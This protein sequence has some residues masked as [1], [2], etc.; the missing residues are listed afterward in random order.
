MLRFVA[1]RIALFI[2]VVL[3]V[4]FIIFT[5][6]YFTPSDPV[7]STLGMNITEEE[8]QQKS[9]ELG[10]DKPFTV[11]F[12]RYLGNIVH[13][14]LGVSY[15]N[16]RSVADQ[17]WE[18]AGKTLLLGGIGMLITVA[19]GIPSGIISATRQYSVLDYSVTGISLFFASMPNFWL[20]LMLIILF[21]LK[22][23]WLP[24]T[25]ISS[26]KGWVLPCLTLG[27]GPLAN[28]TRIT[29]S[30]MLD[31]I[32]QD[33][34]RTAKAKGLSKRATIIKHAL[35]NALIPVITVIGFMLSMI[36]G[37]SAVIEGVF[38][39]PGIGAMLVTAISTADYPLIM[40]SVLFISLF[41]CIV[42]LIVDILYGFIDPRIKAQYMDHRSHRG[43]RNEESK[44]EAA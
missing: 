11:Q 39:F 24:A 1:K 8:Y 15:I 22:L 37:G 26:W 13:L 38:S 35:K 18:R 17:I 27:L 2:P 21:T 42:N 16:K 28:V 20:A 7:Y 44:A 5:I 41:V 23:D 19:I 31:V 25:D 33:Y 40:G 12:V 14:D 6:N 9:Q 32:R 4:L 3:G 29:R 30:S 10:L 36:M 43:N 34:I